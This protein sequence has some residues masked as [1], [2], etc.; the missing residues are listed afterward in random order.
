M[1]IIVHKTDVMVALYPVQCPGESENIFPDIQE[2][3][4]NKMHILSG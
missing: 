1:V 2:F 4:V 3:P